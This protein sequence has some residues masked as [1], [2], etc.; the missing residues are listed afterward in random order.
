MGENNTRKTV[1]WKVI[2][3][4]ISPGDYPGENDIFLTLLYRLSVSG[5]NRNDILT[6]AVNIITILPKRKPE[7][8]NALSIGR[9]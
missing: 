2:F 3:G 1:F 8:R 9:N 5:I 6:S 7:C 4:I